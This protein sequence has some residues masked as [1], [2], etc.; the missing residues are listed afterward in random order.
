MKAQDVLLNENLERVIQGEGSYNV[1]V[2]GCKFN[3]T[4]ANPD[5]AD[6]GTT[7]N[8]TYLF[9]DVKSGAGFLLKL[10]ARV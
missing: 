1:G 10:K 6:L 9:A 7:A 8:W 4:M 3:T 2:K 5:D